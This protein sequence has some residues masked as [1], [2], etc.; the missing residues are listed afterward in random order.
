MNVDSKKSKQELNERSLKKAIPHEEGVLDW[1]I[2]GTRKRGG[3]ITTWK[4]SRNK[5][6]DSYPGGI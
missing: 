1:N 6:K 5:A 2:V 4:V 3:S